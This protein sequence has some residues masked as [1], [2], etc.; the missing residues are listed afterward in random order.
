MTQAVVSVGVKA[1][2]EAEA[3][4]EIAVAV[5]VAVAAAV[6]V[7]SGEMLNAAEL[8]IATGTTIIRP[9]GNL[10]PRVVVA[11]EAVGKI[12]R[13]FVKTTTRQ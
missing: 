13:V 10:R 4:P 5:L 7:V 9:S 8:E 11:T 2:A 12:K 6:G 3:V 1:V